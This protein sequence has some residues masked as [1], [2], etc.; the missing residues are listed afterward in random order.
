[1]TNG[2]DSERFSV[3][4]CFSSVSSVP[5]MRALCHAGS[6]SNGSPDSTPVSTKSLCFLATCMTGING[7]IDENIYIFGTAEKLLP[8][9]GEGSVEPFLDGAPAGTLPG[10]VG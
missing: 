8:G 10:D 3:G 9:D 7:S 4:C 5:A 1:M 2:S 6:P